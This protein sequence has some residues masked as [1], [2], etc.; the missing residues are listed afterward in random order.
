MPYVCHRARLISR[1]HRLFWHVKR[2]L[3]HMHMRYLP[4]QTFD[5]L[6]ENR[7]PIHPYVLTSA[8]NKYQ[9]ESESTRIQIQSKQKWC[10]QFSSAC[11]SLVKVAIHRATLIR[12]D[13][14]L[15]PPFFLIKVNINTE[16]IYLQSILALKQNVRTDFSPCKFR[17]EQ[18]K[19]ENKIEEVQSRN[20]H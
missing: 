9:I 10:N 11:W 5:T 12:D 17:I 14:F 7:S 18:K 20:L 19:N 1:K 13:S 3:A 6:L 2:I 15:I 8:T 16:E 4:T